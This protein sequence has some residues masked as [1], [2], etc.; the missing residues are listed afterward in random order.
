MYPVSYNGEPDG[1]FIIWQ[2]ISGTPATTHGEAAGAI[3]ELYQFACFGRTYDEAANLRETLISSLDN[4][5]LGNG[6]TADLDDAG[7]DD[8][9]PSARIGSV[10][11]LWR[12]DADFLI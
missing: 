8:F 5:T 3:Q 9:D 7:R 11:G 4:Q 6:A 10:E 1:P 12:C 2:K